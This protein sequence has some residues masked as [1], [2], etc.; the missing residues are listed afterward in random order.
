MVIVL[1]IC[2]KF[3]CSFSFHVMNTLY[4]KWILNT[5]C[6]SRLSYHYRHMDLICYLY[7]YIYN[8]YF[9]I[10]LY[11]IEGCQIEVSFAF[12]KNDYCSPRHWFHEAVKQYRL[13]LLD[14]FSFLGQSH[15]WCCQGKSLIA[16]AQL[17]YQFVLQ[18]ASK[19]GK[20]FFF[21]EI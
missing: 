6:G 16:K 13:F 15:K 12:C 14:R 2:L 7:I 1:H 17:M 10:R 8:D 3:A 20:G 21:S 19:W 9:N 4:M 18:R 5:W 11:S